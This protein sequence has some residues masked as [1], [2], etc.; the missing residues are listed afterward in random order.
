MSAMADY[1]IWLREHALADSDDNRTA[2]AVRRR[3][4]AERDA[5]AEVSYGTQEHTEWLA[6]E[7]RTS[8]EAAN[9]GEPERDFAE[10]AASEL[11]LAMEYAEQVG[12]EQMLADEMPPKL[13]LRYRVRRGVRSHFATHGLFARDYSHRRVF[14]NRR[15]RAARLGFEWH[16]YAGVRFVSVGVASPTHHRWWATSV[17]VYVSKGHGRQLVSTALFGRLHSG[18][19]KSWG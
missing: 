11:M 15:F 2:Y 8:H 7:W 6:G 13:P 4:E 10:E 3:T 17:Y 19:Y 5:D 14:I 9:N 12:D 16:N 18:G 1:A